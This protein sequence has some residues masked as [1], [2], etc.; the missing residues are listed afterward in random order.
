[1]NEA[2]VI[3]LAVWGLICLA[4][5]LLLLRRRGMKLVSALWG[6][7]FAAVLGYA[8]AKAFY[9]GLLCTRVW[10]RF[11]WE[12]FLRT[13]GAEFCFFG[14]CLGA[15]LGMALGARLTKTDEKR[16]LSAFAPCGA[17][18]AAGAR[19]AERYLGLLGAGSL[20]ENPTF[21]RFPFAVS[22]Q[23]DEWF[24]A[25][26]MLE[27]LCA[28]A[29]GAVFLA[30]KKEGLLP[31][32]R[33]ERTAFYLCLTQ[34]F[35]ESLRAQGMRWGFV[36]VEQVLCAV[37][38]VGLLVYGC[39]QAEEWRFGK[40]FWPVFASLL[41]IGLIV[42]VEFALDKTDMSPV[43]WY[44]VM[45][46]VLTGFGALECFCTGRRFKQIRFSN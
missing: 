33:L 13:K 20:V 37:C 40:R 45:I 4:L 26:F 44:A 34:I 27:A 10:P 46:A 5:F 17:F 21:Q 39:A 12:A 3:T 19:Y 18:M 29:V 24:R 25:I 11:G 1:M 6:A 42:G 16:F 2:Y 22:N 43:F 36:R 15:V 8:L 32:L 9:V 35:C 23:W 28:L 31:G 30:R 41:C 38:L 14:G 7:V